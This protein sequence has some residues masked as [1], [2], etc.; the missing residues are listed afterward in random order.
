[1]CELL[2]GVDVCLELVEDGFEGVEAFG[3]PFGL[4]GSLLT[5]GGLFKVGLL[6]LLVVIVV[7]YCFFGVDR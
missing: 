3:F 5:F 7:V 6:L 2:L 4:R 1:M